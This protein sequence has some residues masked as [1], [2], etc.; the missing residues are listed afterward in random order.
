VIEKDKQI[1]ENLRA[2]RDKKQKMQFENNVM[3]ETMLNFKDEIICDKISEKTLNK[4]IFENNQ[5]ECCYNKLSKTLMELQV[6]FS[7]I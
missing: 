2:V 5:L 1:L 7:S 3:E 6:D 4:I